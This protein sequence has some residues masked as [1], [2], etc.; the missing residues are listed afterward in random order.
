MHWHIFAEFGFSHRMALICTG[1][2]AG[3]TVGVFLM[4]RRLAALPPN[5]PIAPGENNVASTPAVRDPFSDG[6]ASERRVAVRRKGNL[7]DVMATRGE[8]ATAPWRAT[9][10]DRSVGGVR[11]LQNEAAAVGDEISIRPV[12]AKDDSTWIP[13]FVRDC[14]QTPTGWELGCQFERT[15]SSTVLW[16]LG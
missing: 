8:D 3:L 6:S 5:H 16:E 9:V 1:V 7:V 14:R 13:L 15:P 4:A 2:G 11:L 10:T 12:R